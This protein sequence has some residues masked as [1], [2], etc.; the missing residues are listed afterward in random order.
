VAAQG[1]LKP[2]VDLYEMEQARLTEWLQAQAT[3]TEIRSL[4]ASVRK[5]G[6]PGQS[7]L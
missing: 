6:V 1:H 7:V 2:I 4:G 5:I 3:W